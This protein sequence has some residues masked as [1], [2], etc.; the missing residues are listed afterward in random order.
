VR[1]AAT[2]ASGAMRRMA[3][4][5][6]VAE[7]ALAIILLFGAGLVVRSFS[8]LLS[9]DPG[10]R[11]ERVTTI[12]T[13]LPA[14]RYRDSLTRAAFY[15][16]ADAAIRAVPGVEAVGQAAVIPLTGNNWTVPFER[17]DR[18]LPPGERP[19]EVGWQVATGGFF[20]ALTI[21]LIAGRLFDERDRPESPLVLIVSEA[22]QKRYFA[23]ESAVGKQLKVGD[24]TGE[25]VGVVGDIRRAGLRDD[26]R[27]D[28]YFPA[29]LNPGIQTTFFVRTSGEP[30]ATLLALQAA[31]R[32]VE[33]RIVIE[34]ARPLG[35]I[36]AESVRTTKLVLWLLGVFAATAL[37]LA[38]VGIYGVMS[39]VVRQRTR[40]IGTRIALGA[41][42]FDIV[43]LIMRQ[44]AGIAMI[45]AVTGLV[46]GLIAAKSLGSVLYGVTTSDP[47]SLTTATIV[48]VAAT[49]AACYVPARRAAGVDPARTLAEQ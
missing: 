12:S 31:L 37:V 19:P 42:R 3:S 10:F 15:R 27:P 36:A 25:I 30:A 17:A 2:S 41:T 22:I 35:E 38:A 33:Q 5:L 23:N 28:M 39:Y 26:P 32:S 40:E 8:T 44:G 48:L 24:R 11:Y 9:V 1:P 16:E 14:Q 46:V 4:G 20:K 7:V 29:E 47:L 45:G 43:W 49:L 13:V 18:P 6:V 34:D 21:P